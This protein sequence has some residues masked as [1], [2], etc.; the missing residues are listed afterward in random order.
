MRVPAQLGFGEGSLLG[1]EKAT[2]S[3]GPHGTGKGRENKLSSISSC[4][5][6]NLQKINRHSNSVTL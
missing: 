2:F 6:T 3:I 4:K 1:S 5:S